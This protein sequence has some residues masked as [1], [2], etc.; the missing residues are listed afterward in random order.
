MRVLTITTV[1][2][3]FS[4]LT[5][6]FCPDESSL[7]S[8]V[9]GV[10][11]ADSSC[12]CRLTFNYIS[13]C[14]APNTRDPNADCFVFG[15]RQCSICKEGYFGGNGDDRKCKSARESDFLNPETE[16]LL[17]FQKKIQKQPL[18]LCP[19]NQSKNPFSN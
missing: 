5:L 11:G 10:E 7:K 1:L 13:G 12:S 2:F 9:D 14:T 19:I 18:A 4:N 15:H 16:N 17:L 3:L 6:V 8:K